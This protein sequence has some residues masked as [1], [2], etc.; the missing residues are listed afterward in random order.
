VTVRRADQSERLQP[1]VL[2]QLFSHVTALPVQ[3]TAQL[4]WQPV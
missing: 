3:V 2:S 4:S 1:V